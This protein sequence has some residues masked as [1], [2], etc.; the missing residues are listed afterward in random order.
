MN[1]LFRFQFEHLEIGSAQSAQTGLQKKKI[2]NR[3]SIDVAGSFTD[4]IHHWECVPAVER[5]CGVELSPDLD[6][7]CWDHKRNGIVVELIQRNT[8]DNIHRLCVADDVA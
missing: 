8:G 5:C 4:S 7:C 2:H 3:H 1:I 6:G